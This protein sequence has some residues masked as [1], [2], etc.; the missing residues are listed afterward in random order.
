MPKT[1]EH[2]F[3]SPVIDDYE[4]Y[5]FNDLIARGIV[6]SRSDLSRKICKQGFPR[7]EKS[8]DAMQARAPYRKNK[9][10]AWLDRRAALRAQAAAERA[11]RKVPAA[12]VAEI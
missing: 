12:E 1:R 11:P 5:F 7:P 8:S 4:F 6:T 3:D 2:A 10:H 9:V